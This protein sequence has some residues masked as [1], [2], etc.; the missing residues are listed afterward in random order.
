MAAV[1]ADL[2]FNL[3]RWPSLAVEMR[4]GAWLRLEVFQRQRVWICR[5][6]ALGSR[7]ELQVRKRIFRTGPGGL[8]TS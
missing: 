2:A 8:E 1:A 4:L 5:E 7:V 6:V 3:L